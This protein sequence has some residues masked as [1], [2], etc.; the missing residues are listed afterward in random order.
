MLQHWRRSV[1][2]CKRKLMLRL[3]NRKTKTVTVTRNLVLEL[4]Y[5]TVNKKNLKND[6]YLPSRA[7]HW[8]L[9]LPDWVS[10]LPQAVSSPY[11]H[12]LV[13]MVKA[14]LTG[15]KT[16]LRVTHNLAVTSSGLVDWALK[17]SYFSYTNRVDK[18]EWGWDIVGAIVSGCEWGQGW[19]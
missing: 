14:V 15:Y 5:D 4:K 6:N 19:G 13:H 7:G 17:A 8:D 9:H 11:C 18:W 12:T 10:Y 2:W 16:C 3:W 1:W